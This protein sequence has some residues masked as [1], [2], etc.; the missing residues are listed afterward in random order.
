MKIKSVILAGLFA[1]GL[2]II[3]PAE[4]EGAILHGAYATVVLV[5]QPATCEASL[6]D[7]LCSSVAGFLNDEDAKTDAAVKGCKKNCGLAKKKQALIEAAQKKVKDS[8]AKGITP[9]IAQVSKGLDKP[10]KEKLN[11]LY[12]KNSKMFDNTAELPIGNFAATSAKPSLALTGKSG[13]VLDLKASEPDIN[14][15]SPVSDFSLKNKSFSPL[16]QKAYA[17]GVPELPD[18]PTEE[19]REYLCAGLPGANVGQEAEKQKWILLLPSFIAKAEEYELA[20]QAQPLLG[21]TTFKGVAGVKAD[22]Q[23]VLQVM[24]DRIQRNT[25]FINKYC[26]GEEC[27]GDW[28]NGECKPKCTGGKTRNAAGDCGCSADKEDVNGNCEP[29]CTGDTTRNAAGE[30]VE[31]PKKEPGFLGKLWEDT[32]TV[33]KWPIEKIGD[34]LNWVGGK[35]GDAW[36]GTKEK[37]GETWNQIDSTLR[38]HTEGAEPKS[39]F[40]GYWKNKAEELAKHKG[41]AK[42]SGEF[43]DWTN[44]KSLESLVKER[45][46]IFDAKDGKDMRYVQDS[47][48]PDRIIDM[49]HFFYFGEKEQGS[50]GAWLSAG[51]ISGFGEEV[52]QKV[53]RQSSAFDPQDFYSNALGAQFFREYYKPGGPPLSEQLRKFFKQREVLKK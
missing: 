42:T 13:L 20:C 38:G 7:S 52:V 16:P 29:K 32:K 39:W 6:K 50:L 23:D 53:L 51:D 11:K 4:C 17:V 28:V 31:P 18:P 41:D 44:D 45:G 10:T 40:D 5:F 34:G 2:F 27:S 15:T 36:N 21:C 25:N 3:Q 43:S 1:T 24:D 30:C 37:A 22:W 12:S 48:N 8:C 19:E 26:T 46:G 33:V 14:K 47:A 49:R 35:I 9:D